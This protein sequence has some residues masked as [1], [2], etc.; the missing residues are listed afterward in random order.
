[1]NPL[2]LPFAVIYGLTL[3]GIGLSFLALFRAN[4]STRVLEKRLAAL[5]EEKS[6]ALEPICEAVKSLSAEVRDLQQAPVA[7]NP[8]SPRM[9]FN[10]TKRSQALRMHRRGD[11]PEQIALALEV[12]RQEIDLLLKVHRIVISSI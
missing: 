9:G 8:A 2:I 6:V 1:M 10:L 12:P 7:E 3:A 5:Q 4:T 11:S